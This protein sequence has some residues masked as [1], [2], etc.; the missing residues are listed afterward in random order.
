VKGDGWVIVDISEVPGAFVPEDEPGLTQEQREDARR[1]LRHLPPEQRARNEQ[2]ARDFPDFGERWHAIRQ[3]LGITAFGVNAGEGDAG[4]LLLIPHDEVE[5]GHEELYVVIRGHARFDVDGHSFE[6]GPGHLLYVCPG[7]L[8]SA[9]SLEDGT[10]V[11]AV[12]GRPGSYAPP[13]WSADWRPP[14]E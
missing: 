4:E 12:G 1:R 11:L 10:L 14:V 5:H 9:T 13:I 3:N 6:A 8:R 7:V 2:A